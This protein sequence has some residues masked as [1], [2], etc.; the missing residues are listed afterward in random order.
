M[1]LCAFP[2]QKIHF[3]LPMSRFTCTDCSSFNNISETRWLIY[4]WAIVFGVKNVQLVRDH[5]TVTRPQWV[6]DCVFERWPCLW[7]G[8]CYKAKCDVEGTVRTTHAYFPHVSPGCLSAKDQSAWEI[9]GGTR[10]L[11]MIQSLRH[12]FIVTIYSCYWATSYLFCVLST[13]ESNSNQEGDNLRQR[14]TFCFCIGCF[15]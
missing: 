5:W 8:G 14:F 4:A 12:V 15:I 9:C 6:V 7:V 1:F 10:S 3:I 11:A 13:G 2:V